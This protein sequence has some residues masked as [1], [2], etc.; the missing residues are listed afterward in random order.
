[1]MLACVGIAGLRSSWLWIFDGTGS[2]SG[3][4]SQFC[5]G[6]ALSGGAFGGLS[7]VQ[8]CRNSI[9]HEWSVAGHAERVKHDDYD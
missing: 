3:F 8:F 9:M 1:M 5:G 7:E 4:L 2:L 6:L